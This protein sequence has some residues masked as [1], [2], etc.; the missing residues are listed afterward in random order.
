MAHILTTLACKLVFIDY[1]FEGSAPQKACCY[2]RRLAL[3][4]R[5]RSSLSGI[6]FCKRI[7]MLL[8]ILCVFPLQV[9]IVKLFVKI[10]NNCELEL[11]Q[12][13]EI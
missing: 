9:W 3:T 5:R 2:A 13:L 4:S 1:Q 7:E 10:T 6:G 11:E 8:S 12:G